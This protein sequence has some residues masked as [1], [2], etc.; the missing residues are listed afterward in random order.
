[1]YKVFDFSEEWR[2]KL[3]SIN[4]LKVSDYKLLHG[5]ASVLFTFELMTEKINTIIIDLRKKINNEEQEK[6][7]QEDFMKH[8]SKYFLSHHFHLGDSAFELAKIGYG[9]SISI[10]ARALFESTVNLTYLWLCEDI[11]NGSILER[12]AWREF[13]DAEL[14]KAV[15]KHE[16]F[17]K[18]REKRS[19]IVH[20]N[21]FSAERSKEF[22]KLKE[23]FKHDYPDFYIR[24]K[25]YWCKH[26]NLYER[27]RAIDDLEIIKKLLDN[28]S[29][30]LEDQYNFI[31]GVTSQY[32]H[33]SSK[34]ISAYSSENEK[35]LIIGSDYNTLS[36]P[37]KMLNNSLVISLLV[38]GEV[39]G[40]KK[41]ELYAQLNHCEET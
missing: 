3:N 7:W 10:I 41:E 11:N 21:P 40:I 22:E 31:Y 4:H 35:E 16:D 17:R 13:Y 34:I 37:L 33:G 1:M 15:N 19:D 20:N 9:V 14:S 8:I 23:K 2:N 6:Q 25:N 28:E 26:H 18:H 36:L 29:F 38:I 30:Y 27:A 5:T 24:K 12:K 32:I 39:Y